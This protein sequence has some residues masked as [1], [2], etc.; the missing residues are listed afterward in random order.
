MST[1]S[2][3]SA[4]SEGE[5]DGWI[6]V[7]VASYETS[8]SGPLELAIRL[9]SS[10]GAELVVLCA[11]TQG[12][13][14]RAA[15]DALKILPGEAEFRSVSARDTGVRWGLAVREALKLASERGINARRLLFIPGDPDPESL[16]EP[17]RFNGLADG[18]AKMVARLGSLAFVVGDYDIQCDQI[19]Q[20]WDSFATIPFFKVLFPDIADRVLALGLTKWRSEFWAMDLTQCRP[21][22][23]GF[24]WFSD[25]TPHLIATTLR[26]GGSVG[27]VE[28]GEFSD[29]GLGRDDLVAKQF[30]AIRLALE[31]ALVRSAEDRAAAR[32][33]D[34]DDRLKE[35]AK[36]S[37]ALRSAMRALWAALEACLDE[38]ED[39]VNRLAEERSA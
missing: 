21:W 23:D 27:A 5:K 16:Q 12:E 25:P 17:G 31:S 1:Q 2:V 29:E 20:E 28:L 22:L 33:L 35:G 34:G 39:R 11:D 9:A 10:I 3:K 7:I 24:A 26:N 15:E 14:G 19:K 36:V 8:E 4:K 13:S 6:I 38:I 30:Q 18:L 32:K 37:R